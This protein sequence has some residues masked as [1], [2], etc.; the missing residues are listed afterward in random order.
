MLLV[1]E[2]RFRKIFITYYN[3]YGSLINTIVIQLF[4]Q[5]EITK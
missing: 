2:L 3:T 4:S 5:I 1:L